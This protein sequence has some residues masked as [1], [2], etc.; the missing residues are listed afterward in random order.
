MSLS[1]TRLGALLASRRVERRRFVLLMAAG[2]LGAAVGRGTAELVEEPN[3]GGAWVDIARRMSLRY[4]GPHGPD[5]LVP[6]L[7]Q[8]RWLFK[9][10]PTKLI[11]W[12]GVDWHPRYRT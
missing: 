7:N 1:G 9:V 11:T 6:T 12:Q 5:Y 4:L 3:V 10:T 2:V 8:P